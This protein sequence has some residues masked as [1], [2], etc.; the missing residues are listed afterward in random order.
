MSERETLTA[1]VL[2][3]DDVAK[4]LETDV[5]RY[6]AAGFESEEQEALDQLAT[7]HPWRW[8]KIAQLQER[9]R[10]ARRFSTMAA[11][12][13]ICGRQALDQLEHPQE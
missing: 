6:M 10:L 7:V 11:E 4:W 5:G 2:L 8:R 12:A 1:E 3:G 9:I 13:I